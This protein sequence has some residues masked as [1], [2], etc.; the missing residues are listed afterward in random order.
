MQTEAY[1]LLA[2]VSF[3]DEWMEKSNGEG[4]LTTALGNMWLVSQ[5]AGT[6]S[7]VGGL[8]FDIALSYLWISGYES[9]TVLGVCV[10]DMKRKL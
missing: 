9:E 5:Q 8:L 3:H 6:C 2:K 1:N 10:F 4:T 7:P